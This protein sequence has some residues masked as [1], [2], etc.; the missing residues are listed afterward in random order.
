MYKVFSLNKIILFP[1]DISCTLRLKYTTIVIIIIIIIYYF[2]LT[3][4]SFQGLL[5]DLG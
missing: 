3:H 1:N 4:C 5:Y 2:Q